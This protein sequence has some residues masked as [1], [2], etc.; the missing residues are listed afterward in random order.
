[1]VD[2][3][4]RQL[5]TWSW[6]VKTPETKTKELTG[7]TTSQKPEIKESE[8]ELTVKAGQMNYTFSKV[9]GTIQQIKQGARLI[10]LSNGPLFVSRDKK[11]K[12]VSSHFECD[13]LIIETNYDNRD[14]TKWTVKKDGMVDLEVSYEPGN[15]SLFAGIT[16]SYPE[17][18]CRRNEMDGQRSIPCL[19]KPDERHR[20]RS[21]GKGLQQLH[22]R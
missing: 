3:Y 22:H 5:N 1:M 10:P 21:L 12:Q 13:D 11:V 6:P 18:K 16:F 17:E 19:Q 7:G 8:K 9:D 14:W 20:I 2:L 15:S 4:G